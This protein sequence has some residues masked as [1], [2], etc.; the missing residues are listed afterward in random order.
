VMEAPAGRTAPPRPPNAIPAEAAAPA[1]ARNRRRVILAMRIPPSPAV[2]RGSQTA[3]RPLLLA[4]TARVLS[5]RGTRSEISE[6]PSG[7]SWGVFRKTCVQ[8]FVR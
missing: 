4:S 8:E 5:L 3:P 6:D 1:R 2:F 7:D